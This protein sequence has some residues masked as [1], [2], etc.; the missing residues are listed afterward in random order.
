MT[1]T[2]R[3]VVATLLL[4]VSVGAPAGAQD[5]APALSDLAAARLEAAHW[6]RAALAQQ[7]AAA[8]AARERADK[9]LTDLI[10]SEAKAA[11][12]S[13]ADGWVVDLDAKKWVKRPAP[14]GK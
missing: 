10:A 5:K 8:R 11:G 13:T 12:V 6:K 14:E 4:I 1:T 2:R 3:M 9:D 7:E